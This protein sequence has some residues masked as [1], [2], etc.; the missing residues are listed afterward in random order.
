[1]TTTI[2]CCNI[3]AFDYACDI[4]APEN[5]AS[6]YPEATDPYG[7]RNIA[8]T[9]FLI[10]S[11]FFLIFPI[12]YAYF[13]KKDYIRVYTNL[14]ALIFS[15]FFHL[16]KTQN[17]TD[18]FCITSFCL[19]RTY[20]YIFSLSLLLS[21]IFL[22]V[23]Y[24]ILHVLCKKE[25]EQHKN[26][27]L[28]EDELIQGNT[29]ETNLF[30]QNRTHVQILTLLLNGLLINILLNQTV[31]CASSLM[32]YFFLIIIGQ[33]FLFHLGFSL[34]FYFSSSSSKSDSNKKKHYSCCTFSSRTSSSLYEEITI[35]KL[36]NTLI[37]IL[38]V[39]LAFIFFLA[40]EYF[41]IY[42]YWLFHSLWHILAGLGQ[43]YFLMIVE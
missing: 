26:I 4:S 40:R 20:D 41:D 31:F 38:L 25:D 15:C 6:A 13:W 16:C 21:L 8:E 18:G 30:I 3:N 12:V 36:G 9:I 17:K 2:N 29:K 35:K 37:G 22:I 39:G 24:I 11:N 5:P 23:E 10:S 42:Y 32:I 27:N 14:F 28:Q 43:I 1:M 19:L 7:S 34:L 33:G